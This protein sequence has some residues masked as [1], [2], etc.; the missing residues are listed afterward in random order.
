MTPPDDPVSPRG[1]ARRGGRELDRVYRGVDDELPFGRYLSRLFE[2]PEG[3]ARRDSEA[4]VAIASTLRWRSAVSGDLRRFGADFEKEAPFVGGLSGAEVLDLD[5]VRRRAALVVED[6]DLHE[7]RASDLRSERKAP[8]HREVAE[9][10]LTH[11][12]AHHDEREEHPE[13]EIEEVVP[14]VDRGEAHAERD[15]DEELPFARELELARR[16]HRP[17]LRREQARP[18]Q[19][20]EEEGAS[21]CTGEG[22]RAPTISEGDGDAGDDLAKRGLGFV[23]RGGEPIGMGGEADTVR[24]DGDGEIVDVVRDAI[25]AA[26]EEGTRTRGVPERDRAA[27]RGA[28]GE[29][30]GAPGGLDERVEVAAERRVDRHPVH[31]ALEGDELRRV[32]HDRDVARGIGL[33]VE[34]EPH[35][36]LRRWVADA[37]AEEESIE[38]GFGEREQFRRSPAGSA[39]R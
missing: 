5:G 4:D 1:A 14:R 24:E 37:H 6:L 25:V 29:G 10:E 17:P 27:R 33:P 28:Q 18:L 34:E 12:S 31:L 16:L 11:K 39:S 9:R 2:E 32:E 36:H 7:V 15:P 8:D 35:F 21:G 19:R 38:L 30:G 22:I 20:D 13:E 23:A 26:A 3:K